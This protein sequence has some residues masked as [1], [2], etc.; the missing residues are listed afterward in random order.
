M[1]VIILIKVFRF[2][3]FRL[4]ISL[5]RTFRALAN[6]DKNTCLKFPSL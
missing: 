2:C 4:V 5:A 3:Y 6:A 1:I